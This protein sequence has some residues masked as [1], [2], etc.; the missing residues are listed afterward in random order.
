MRIHPSLKS[1]VAIVTRQMLHL[2][3]PQAKVLAIWSFGIA[4]TQSS[5]LTT[6]SVFLA[7]LLGIKEN[8]VRQR[9]REWL[10]DADD[11]KGKH[12]TEID[13][14]SCFAPLLSWILSQW[15]PGEEKLALALDATTL[16]KRFTVLAISV[17]YRGSAIPVAW[18]I[19]KANEKGAWKPYW[20]ELFTHIQETIPPSWMVIVTAER[21]LYADWLY[22][23]IVQLGWHPYLRINSGGKFQFPGE[24]QWKALR[25][26]VS[27][28][29]SQWCARI[30]C[31]K[32][33]T[34][35]C[36]LVTC[37]EADYAEPWLIV[38]DL[39]PSEANSSWY[40]MRSWIESSFKDTKRG[41]FLW[42]QTKTTAPA[43]A[44]RHWLAMAL[45]MLWLVSVGGE[46][47]VANHPIRELNDLEPTVASDSGLSSS[48][49]RLLSC[50]RRG[51]LSILVALLWGEP[52]PLGHFYSFPWT[53]SVSFSSA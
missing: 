47:E 39:A 50:F 44:E 52:L 11:K 40:A 16:G 8:T 49:P 17:L 19:V 33:Q 32:E 23:K 41:G 7:K 15:Q 37:W 43:R 31:F 51:F 38:T 20:L 18:K 53:N 3:K 6:V 21:G 42:H 45:A 14:T 27:E 25:E 1:W 4:M 35:D 46:D 9:L 30:R 2:S 13:V 24:K 28:R 22:H 5:G 12:R 36:T 48:P 26:V 34:I 29:D 10:R